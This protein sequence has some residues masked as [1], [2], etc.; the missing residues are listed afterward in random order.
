MTIGDAE[1]KRIGANRK[2]VSQRNGKP[3]FDILIELKRVGEYVVHEN[4]ITS[5]DALLA[6]PGNLFSLF[7]LI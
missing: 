2:N 3:V 7:D 5:V 6:E 1:M 4:V